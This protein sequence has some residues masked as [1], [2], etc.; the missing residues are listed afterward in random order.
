MV[1]ILIVEDEDN[2]VM[3]FEFFLVCVGYSYI[4]FVIGIGMLDEICNCWFDLVL[5]DIMLFDILGY[6]IMGVMCVDLQMCGV[7]VLMMMV[8]GFVVE[9]KKGLELG[10]DG[11]IVKFFELVELWVEMVCLLGVV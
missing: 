3:V 10:V 11:F 9:C 5:L 1:Y 8:C 4:C 6:E 7:C 2:I